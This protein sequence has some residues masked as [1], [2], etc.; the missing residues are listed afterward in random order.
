MISRAPFHP[1][2]S[3]SGDDG[4][5]PSPPFR[6]GVG[7]DGSPSGDDAVVL[8][9][10]LARGTSAELM[11]TASAELMLTAVYEEPLLEPVVPRRRGSWS[12]RTSG[13]GGVCSACLNAGTV[14][15]SSWAPVAV[16]RMGR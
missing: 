2:L 7:A 13:S 14:I 3:R 12:I 6:I 8:A 5:R 10:Q 15:C 11:L 4:S 1:R 9:S 16:P